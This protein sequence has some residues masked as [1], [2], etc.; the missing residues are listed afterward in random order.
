MKFLILAILA[1]YIAFGC[2]GAKENQNS[3]NDRGMEL[4]QQPKTKALIL[5]HFFQLCNSRCP[6]WFSIHTDEFKQPG[7][8]EA[9]HRSNHPSYLL[10][11]V[12][13][14]DYFP[15]EQVYFPR[16]E[17]PVHGGCSLEPTICKSSPRC[18]GW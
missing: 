7:R 16:D 13:I 10:A 15:N 14:D 4:K 11:R 8:S 1:L 18:Q 6:K 2:L 5:F 9:N 12:P 17:S 3:N